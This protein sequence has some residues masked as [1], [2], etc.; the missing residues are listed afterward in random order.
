MTFPTLE[1]CLP[2]DGAR[3]QA[4]A[5]TILRIAGAAVRVADLLARG[6]LEGALGAS[7]EARTMRGTIRSISTS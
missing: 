1:A 7:V 3:D 5:D 4:V 6:P 2:R